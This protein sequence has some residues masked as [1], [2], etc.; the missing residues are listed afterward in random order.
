MRHLASGATTLIRTPYPLVPLRIPSARGLYFFSQNRDA[1]K[2]T[3]D[4]KIWGAGCSVDAVGARPE[5]HEPPATRYALSAMVRDSLRRLSLALSE[6]LPE[7]KYHSSAASF[8]SQ[9]ASPPPPSAPTIS[10]T[11]EIRGPRWCKR[12]MSMRAR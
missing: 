8:P 11:V 12:R 6:M 3:L 7:L 10:P 5:A 1:A 9:L 2:L 4:A